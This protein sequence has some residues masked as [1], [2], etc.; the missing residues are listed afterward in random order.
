MEDVGDDKIDDDLKEY[1]L[2][3]YDE[4]EGL[5]NLEARLLFNT[6]V[7]LKSSILSDEKDE[8]MTGKV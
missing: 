5:E 2:D 6:G 3:N 7:D 4:E 1:N 8:Y